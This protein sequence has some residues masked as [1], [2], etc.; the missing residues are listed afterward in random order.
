M[1]GQYYLEDAAV[2]KLPGPADKLKAVSDPAWIVIEA[3]DS[4]HGLVE[5]WVGRVAELEAYFDLQVLQPRSS[6]R[7]YYHDPSRR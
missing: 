6:V 5:P 2:E 4:I 7:V 1:I 3:E